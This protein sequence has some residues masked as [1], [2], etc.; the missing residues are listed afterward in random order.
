MSDLVGTPEDKC[1]FNTE[2]CNCCTRTDYLAPDQLCR[3]Q[4]CKQ[5]KVH[6]LRCAASMDENAE[7]GLKNGIYM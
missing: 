5:L 2:C 1:A 4:T 3:I 6:S 7:I